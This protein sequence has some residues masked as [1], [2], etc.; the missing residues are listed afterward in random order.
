MHAVGSASSKASG[1]SQRASTESTC[2]RILVTPQP[3]ETAHGTAVQGERDR[4]EARHKQELGFVLQR[5]GEVGILFDSKVEHGQ[6][7]LMLQ[8]AVGN[9]G[10]LQPLHTA[11]PHKTLRT[12]CQSACLSLCLC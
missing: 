8:E 2:S 10:G 7:G 1:S 4:P 9:Q 11:T 12:A 3:G 5:L 6:L